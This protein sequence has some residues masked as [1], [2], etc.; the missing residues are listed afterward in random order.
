MIQFEPP[1][2]TW[3]L[4]AALSG[5][6]IG[7]SIGIAVTF[8][9]LRGWKNTLM[10]RPGPQLGPA[11]GIVPPGRSMPGGAFLP[12]KSGPGLRPQAGK[13]KK[14]VTIITLKDIETTEDPEQLVDKF[15]TIPTGT[16]GTLQKTGNGGI[17]AWFDGDNNPVWVPKD[18]YKVINS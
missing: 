4:W 3:I 1:V 2:F 17:W 14:D 8:F 10:L 15:K 5:F 9:I 12:G 16:R 13:E 18:H 11:A 7:V 6:C